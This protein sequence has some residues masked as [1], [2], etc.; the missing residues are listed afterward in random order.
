[1]AWCLQDVTGAA[2]PRKDSNTSPAVSKGGVEMVLKS[3]FNSW[4]PAEE[5]QP[6]RET[7]GAFSTMVVPGPTGS[8]A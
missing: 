8:S 4:L 3:C 6:S 5:R 2:T 7:A 1:M